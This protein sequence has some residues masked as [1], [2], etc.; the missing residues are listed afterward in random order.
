MA[1]VFI[2]E[3]TLTA[4]GDAIREKE[5]TTALVPVNDMAT[6]ISAIETGSNPIIEALEITNNGIYTATDCDG[7]SPIT[8]NVPQD[9]GPPEEA[10]VLSRNCGSRFAYDGWAWFFDQ[11]KDR[12]TT[13]K[14]TSFANMFYDTSITEIPFDLNLTS[15]ASVQASSAF[16]NATKLIKVP[17]IKGGVLTA[18]SLFSSCNSLKEIPEDWANFIDFSAMHSSTSATCSEIFNNCWRLRY[19]PQ[20]LLTELYSKGTS[21]N[22]VPYVSMFYNCYSLDTINSLAVAPGSITSNR[23]T[24]TVSNCSRLG[25]LTFTT[26]ADGSPLIAPWKKQILDAATGLGYL[27]ASV[28]V[29]TFLKNT[30][31]T[32]DTRVVDDATYEALKDNPDWWTSDSAYSRYNHASA[33]ETINSLP[34]T[35]AVA[36]GSSINTIKF[37]GD[38]GSATDGGA[39]NTLTAEEIA[40][41]AAKGWTVTLV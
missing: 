40:V 41:A 32:E 15:Y 33:V 13:D 6:R 10:F 28:S 3:T 27:A 17:Y 23:F 4:I 24:S 21:G 37:K 25:S 39:I 36:T 2:E 16:S 8:V 7:Y 14:I 5:G 38:A 11:Y 30:D 34:D 12:I 22:Y 31:F 1:K 26:N 18:G 20:N 19:I 35:S 29:S 9:G